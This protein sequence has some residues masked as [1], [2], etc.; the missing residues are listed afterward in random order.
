MHQH[1]FPLLSSPEVE[2]AKETI[3]KIR[4][5]EKAATLKEQ[6]AKQQA[7]E[8]ITAAESEAGSLK[9]KSVEIEREKGAAGLKAV[10]DEC[11]E[12]ETELGTG[13]REK[14]D[15]LE[16]S[17]RAKMPEAVNAVIASLSE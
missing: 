1:N 9:E 16:M 3:D 15:V 5:A 17:A 4:E 10:N 13:V 2:M 14:L 11:K 12:K 7:Q 8:M 6:K